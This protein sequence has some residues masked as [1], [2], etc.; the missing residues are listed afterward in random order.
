LV[1]SFTSLIVGADGN[2]VL[3]RQPV[4]ANVLLHNNAIDGTLDI[5]FAENVTLSANRFLLP[6]GRLRIHESRSI[7]VEG[8]KLGGLPLDRLDQIIVSDEP[9]R[10]TITIR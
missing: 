2:R 3:P 9:T 1:A 8:N 6:R 10:R 5:G 4:I 7:L